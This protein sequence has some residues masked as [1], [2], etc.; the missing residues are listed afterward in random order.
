MSYE[1]EQD[2]YYRE[3]R[4]RQRKHLESLNGGVNWRPCMHE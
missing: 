2:R 3:L 1:T 4:E